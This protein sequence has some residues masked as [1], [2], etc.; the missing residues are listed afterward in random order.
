MIDGM[1][2]VKI[3]R[4]MEGVRS[5]RY[6]MY[7]GVI[8]FLSLLFLSLRSVQGIVLGTFFAAVALL[9]ALYNY[10]TIKNNRY[11][12]LRAKYLALFAVA[13]VV[14]FYASYGIA[15]GDITLVRSLT[16]ALIT[17]T[18]ISA[19]F[20]VTMYEKLKEITIK[21][22]SSL[23]REILDL[24]IRL[25]TYPILISV[26][27]VF[28]SILALTVSGSNFILSIFL[29]NVTITAVLLTLITS[30]EIL[31]EDIMRELE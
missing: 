26:G 27:A 15:N 10:T 20:A 23:S 8:L 31:K 17:A 11:I 24:N 28:A 9:I 29:I 30:V 18:S 6:I 13:A 7:T 25:A 1:A 2:K 21:N 4:S 22:K 16:G 12:K 5:G 19:V 3:A 14:G